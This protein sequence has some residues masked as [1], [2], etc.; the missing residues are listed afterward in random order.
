MDDIGSGDGLI[1]KEGA[2]VY[3][4]SVYNGMHSAIWCEKSHISYQ[5]GRR[6][7]QIPDLSNV[8][9]RILRTINRAFIDHRGPEFAKL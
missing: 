8:S 2:S 3:L 4:A 7:L 5:A 6:L 1:G 9:D